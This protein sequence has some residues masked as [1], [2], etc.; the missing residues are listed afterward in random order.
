MGGT[1][2]G[3]VT[4]NSTWFSFFLVWSSEMNV[5]ENYSKVTVKTYWAP[6]KGYEY[7]DFDTTGTRKASITINGVTKTISKRFD[8]GNDWSN[9]N[10]YLIQTTTQT[11]YHDDDGTK[12][13]YISARAN[14]R[15]ADSTTNYGPSSSS[16]SSGDCTVPST[17]I[18]LDTIP[19]A[20]S[21]TSANSITLGQACNIKWTPASSTFKY[22]I[23]FSLGNWN[24]TTDY[25][26]PSTT[27]AYEY[28]GYTI[29]G[30]VTA[31]D[32]TIYKEL[33]SSP[34]GTMT[35]T[36][37][38][39]N[40]NNEQI[41]SS[42]TET[43]T[44]T[45]PSD[46]APTIGQINCIP[47][48]INDNSI[49]VKGKNTITVSVSGSVPGSGSSIDHYTFE[50]L[51]GSSVIASKS[52]A[53][54]SV[55]FGPF[56]Q[57]GTLTFR[58]TV[59]DKRKRYDRDEYSLNCYDYSKP[60]FSSFNIYRANSDG[61]PDMGGTYIQCDYVPKF[62]SVNGTNSAVVKAFYNGAESSE[63]ENG[64]IRINVGDNTKTYKVYLEIID[65]Y[66]ENNTTSIT[67]IFGDARVLNITSDGT[68]VAIGK[69]AEK[70]ELFECR[71][72]A[73]FD[74]AVTIPDDGGCPV[75]NG[76]GV[77]TLG[78]GEAIPSGSDLNTYTTPGVFS[79]ASAS[80]SGTLINTPITSC[81]FRLVVEYIGGSSY[82]RQ[83]IISRTTNCRTYKRYKNT[84]SWY[85]WQVVLTDGN[86]ADYTDGKFLPL[87]GGTLTGQLT[88]NGGPLTLDD[89][90]YYDSS[91][92]GGLDCRNSD[93]INANGIYF[94][95][96]SN[97]AGEGIN[98]YNSDGVW[99]TLFTAGGALKY[100]AGRGTSDALGG[101]KVI[102][103]GHI[104][105]NTCTL[106]SSTD[107]TITFT[108]AL[109]GT[110]TVILTP[111]TS[112]AGV[113]PGKVKSV[114]S[115]GFTAIIGGSAV[116]EAKF[117]YLAIYF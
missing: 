46:V 31:N 115:T 96:A 100:H 12:S 74:D 89:A 95:D 65:A 57:T 103:A 59:V 63:G 105:R 68:G 60:Y 23:K 3:K 34:S 19:R 43:F 99:D 20:S 88:L 94:G 15:A 40:Y 55:T 32:T 91:G 114:S 112:T 2:Q 66:G 80:V 39:Y 69:M 28:T 6:K 71:W 24:Y 13:I 72:P 41:G 110:P 22:K 52:V 61:S 54:T 50:V 18:I 84:N 101:Y 93:I 106:S 25:I 35:A 27:N 102:T 14:G 48:A 44:V 83:T 86:V 104:R 4:S 77:E 42:D 49:L 116:S 92:K 81:G 5:A 78:P 26:S 38:T 111:L 16:E 70:S 1:I 9:G 36:L 64:S 107:T 45:I 10:P 79:S 67:T 90:I 8:T 58:V 97:S 30:T 47:N 29:S 82:I 56:S 85:D 73:K 75:L 7:K 62:S 113:I 21:I 98:F 87:S 11:V 37:T 108:P 117:A 33:P 51:N 17:E 76:Y 53:N 109:G